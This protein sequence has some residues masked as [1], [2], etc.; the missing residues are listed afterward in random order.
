MREGGGHFI[1]LRMGLQKLQKSDP[2]SHRAV[3]MWAKSL[4]IMRVLGSARVGMVWFQIGYQR[5]TLTM[6]YS[7]YPLPLTTTFAFQTLSQLENRRGDD[8]EAA[9]DDPSRLQELRDHLLRLGSA[10]SKVGCILI[11]KY[12][13]MINNYVPTRITRK[14]NY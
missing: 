6:Y 10:E 11:N 2:A 1:P 8:N 4:K 13:C 7:W 5:T 9:E 14:A 3:D 12:M